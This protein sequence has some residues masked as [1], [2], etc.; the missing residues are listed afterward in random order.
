M[1]LMKNVTL[2]AAVSAIAAFSSANSA[3]AFSFKID[4]GVNGPGGV[5]NQGAYSKF[6]NLAGTTTIDFNSGSAPTTGIVQYSFE[7]NDGSSSVRKDVW[8]PAGAKGE[9][10]NTNYLAVFQG[11]AVT[12]NLQRSMNYFGI[13]WGAISPGNVFSFYMGDQLVKS[14]S[15][16][17]VN[18][19][20]PVKAAQHGGEGNGYLHFYA[21]S[22]AE[23][24]N[25]IVITQTGGGGFE[26]DNHSFHAG[27]GRFGESAVGARTRHDD[28]FNGCWRCGTAETEKPEKRLTLLRL[29]L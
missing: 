2:I 5:T 23:I 1:K 22:A 21:D 28:W 14:Y 18:P 7:K 17:D 13:D 3:Q 10:N 11:N 26:S 19:V 8:A 16:T 4:A 6:A 27:T 25:K 29:R 24:F 12:M 9:V 20:A 15:T